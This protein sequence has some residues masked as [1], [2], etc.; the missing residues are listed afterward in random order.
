MRPRTGIRRT[1]QHED[2]HVH[3]GRTGANAIAIGVNLSPAP[4][5]PELRQKFYAKGNASNASH[6]NAARYSQ[7]IVSLVFIHWASTCSRELS[8]Q[9]WGI[10][11]QDCISIAG[12]T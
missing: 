7:L 11:L 8:A 12:R 3:H 10:P 5:R 9:A 4:E 2:A 6:P 1:C